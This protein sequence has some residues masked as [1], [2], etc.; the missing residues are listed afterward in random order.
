[1]QIKNNKDNL[2][3]ILHN[4]KYN[5]YSSYMIERLLKENKLDNLLSKVTDTEV[6]VKNPVL[7]EKNYLT[8]QEQFFTILCNY[9]YRFKNEF[10]L[11]NGITDFII[12]S[13]LSQNNE[14]LD[15]LLSKKYVHDNNNIEYYKLAYCKS[16]IY[17]FCN[18]LNN[19]SNY[20]KK[21]SSYIER[22]HLNINSNSD[23]DIFNIFTI[24][25]NLTICNYDNINIILLFIKIDD[26]HIES[27]VVSSQKEI[28]TK[29]FYIAMYEIFIDEYY[30]KK[31]Y[32]NMLFK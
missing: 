28:A 10:P 25:K 16:I 18:N 6:I 30:K 12:E 19:L 31:K 14:N 4:L 24:L 3:E 27:N 17:A 11:N 1:M 29:N 23:I 21:I 20:S 15:F 13:I 5:D 2:I 22:E 7:L 26:Y 32:I 9:I 8:G